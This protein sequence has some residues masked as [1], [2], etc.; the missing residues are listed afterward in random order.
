MVR[1]QDASKC[2]QR[3][4]LS[5][6]TRQRIRDSKKS[7][8]S[9]SQALKSTLDWLFDD[10]MFTHTKFHGNSK[11]EPVQ[12]VS[13]ALIW[14][15]QE[16]TN[17]TGA[18]LHA[19]K[20]CTDLGMKETTKTYPRFMNAMARH[21]VVFHSKLK[22]KIQ[23]CAEE[24]AGRFWR[25]DGWVLMAFDGSRVSAPRT[26]S[27]ER[28]FC[29]TNYGKGTTAKYRKKKTKGMRRTNN[30]KNKP[31]P[32][33]PQVWI[34]MICHMALRLPWTWR[35]GPTDSSERADV[36]EM[37][38]T[39]KFPE[40]TLFCGDAGFVGYPL[41][42]QIKL[43]KADFLVRVG[44]NVHLL[45]K[46]ADIERIN[47]GI[48]LCWPKD[49]IRAGE[50]P[51]RV[52]LVKVKIGKT[53]MWMLT[54]VLDR[55]KLKKKQIVRY[56]EM[57]WGIEVEYRGLKQTLDK[58]KLRCRTSDHVLVELDW[59]MFGMAIAELLALREQIPK[60]GAQKTKSNYQPKDLSL[61]NSVAAIRWCM[62]YI[63]DVPKPNED[64][65]TKL[66]KAVVQEYENKTNKQARYRPPNPDKKPLGNPKIRD[67][68]DYERK[69]LPNFP[70]TTAA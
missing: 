47:D 35:L 17:V 62:S 31:A 20:L 30:E 56:Y 37:L 64:L 33:E 54:S 36:V 4:R 25:A 13:Q 23:D 14:S 65:F 44:G 49:K 5:K 45:S 16:T 12:L 48:V 68:D 50:P 10:D 34:T 6:R 11:W 61:A 46:L 52:R 63:N 29:A 26:V 38:R 41:W 58:R 32:Q 70:Q 43:S 60:N 51:I 3:T 67:F 21:R 15:L 27:N 9:N 19:Q 69:K 40:K 66:S 57:R 1:K 7:R 22:A 2:K 24:I 59:S 18:F 42:K 8:V 53:D 39:E 28:A 55:K